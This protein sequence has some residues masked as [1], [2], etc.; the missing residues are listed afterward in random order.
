MN[1]SLT[2]PS[3][4]DEPLRAECVGEVEPAAPRLF[5]WYSLE[6]AAGAVVRSAIATLPLIALTYVLVQ[7]GALPL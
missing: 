2:T 6:T 3:K 1:T 5:S 4:Q 7:I